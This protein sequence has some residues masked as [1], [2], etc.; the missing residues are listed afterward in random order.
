M[1]KSSWGAIFRYTWADMFRGMGPDWAR[2]WKDIHGGI[3]GPNTPLMWVLKAIITV[4][5]I[6]VSMVVFV[7]PLM[8]TVFF[9]NLW[10]NY[11]RFRSPDRHYAAGRRTRRKLDLLLR[12]YNVVDIDRQQ[13]TRPM[14]REVM[15][16]PFWGDF[17]RRWR[18][19]ASDKPVSRDD[20][21][22][23]DASGVIPV[24]LPLVR[25][26]AGGVS[27][28]PAPQR[29]VPR[30]SKRL[31]RPV[32]RR[33][34][35]VT[36]VTVEGES[37]P[38]GHGWTIREE[39]VAGHVAPGLEV[40]VGRMYREPEGEEVKTAQGTLDSGEAW[41][42]ASTFPESYILSATGGGGR[43]IRVKAGT[44]ITRGQL[45]VLERGKAYPVLTTAEINR[46]KEIQEQ[47]AQEFLS[48]LDPDMADHK[49]S[50]GRMGTLE[51]M[52]IH[53]DLNKPEQ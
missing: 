19:V 41:I 36:T 42:D 48:M 27:D 47:V 4:I 14:V 31:D 45:V 51:G 2:T 37:R 6:L 50:F 21:P 33:S 1:K 8:I 18:S 34:V 43:S 40:K 46:R 20:I 11:K 29:T 5:I 24:V 12:A 25:N 52:T 3:Y 35:A 17:I 44:E 10:E 28:I 39:I 32:K 53:C 38:L 9:G 15:F 30:I 22:K 23:P 26:A 13:G 16:E 49:F 7:I